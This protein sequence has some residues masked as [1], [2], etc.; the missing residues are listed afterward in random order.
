M[1]Q[2]SMAAGS[3]CQEGFQALALGQLT[4]VMRV[5]CNDAMWKNGSNHDLLNSS[6]DCSAMPGSTRRKHST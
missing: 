4:A 5:S 3:I 1:Q 6:D 2:G